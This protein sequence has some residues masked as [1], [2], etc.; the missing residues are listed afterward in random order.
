MSTDLQIP[1]YLK[2]MMASTSAPKTEDMISGGTSVPRI[3]LRGM[4][5]RFKDGGEE[6]EVV[7]DDLDCII[8]GMLPEHGTAKTFY[9]GAYNPDSSD[10]PDCS[11]SNGVTPDGWVTSPVSNNCATCPNNKFGSAISQSGK[12]AKACRDSKRLYIVKAQ[13]MKQDEPPYWL[14][15]VTVSSLKPLN[16][17]SKSLSSK[18]ISTPSVVVTR[19]GFD[20]EAE[21]PKLTFKAM[22]VL[23]ENMATASLKIAE[24]K[25]WEMGLTNSAPKIESKQDM[26]AI[27]DNTEKPKEV[28]GEV[29]SEEK[30]K[31]EATESVD[32]ILEQW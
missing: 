19:L 17:Y 25:E 28:E 1:D 18:G 24:K 2:D 26:P 5:F 29:V 32:D 6:V 15:N 30:P 4:K 13:D 7:K 27:E 16:E 11:S 20:D 31:R 9:E 8:V 23:N 14:L 10:P 21:F 12:K 22:G 3:S